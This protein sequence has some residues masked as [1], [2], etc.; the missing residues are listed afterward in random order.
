MY[1]ERS[2][3]YPNQFTFGGVIAKRVN[4]VLGSRKVNLIRPKNSFKANNNNNNNSDDIFDAVVM[5]K[6]ATIARVHQTHSMN[7]N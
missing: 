6:L 5:A 7:A 2:E 3:F 1:S 4:A